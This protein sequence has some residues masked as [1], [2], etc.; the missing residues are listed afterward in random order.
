MQARDALRNQLAS[1]GGYQT[2]AER[3]G[4]WEKDVL[5]AVYGERFVCSLDPHLWASITV[6]FGG[7]PA[8]GPFGFG[9]DWDWD[10]PD[11]LDFWP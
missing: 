2:L 10:V 1:G 4:D 7:V 3:A 9:R 5:A 11:L 6:T 8:R